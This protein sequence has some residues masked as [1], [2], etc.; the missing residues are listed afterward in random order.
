MKPLHHKAMDQRKS[1]LAGFKL[2]ASATFTLLLFFVLLVALTMAGSHFDQKLDGLQNELMRNRWEMENLRRENELLREE[3][4]GL[5]QGQQE[6][7]ERFEV[8]DMEATGYTLA[9]G[10]GDGFTATMTRPEVGRTIAVD[11]GVIPYGSRVWIDGEGPYV[12][13]DTGFLIKGDR[14]DIYMGEG[15]EA[16]RTAMRWGRQEVQIIYE[17][18]KEL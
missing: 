8:R 3:L 16:Y 2:L 14:I 1:I 11:P 13:E 12:A 9:C 4:E 7:L 17:R 6:W 15:Q 5:R 10:T 18:G